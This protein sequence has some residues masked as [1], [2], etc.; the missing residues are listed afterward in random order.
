MRSEY[1]MLLLLPLCLVESARKGKGV[2]QLP[3][4]I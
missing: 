4:V 2:K 1:Q 3:G